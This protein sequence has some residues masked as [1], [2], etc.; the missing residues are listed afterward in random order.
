MLCKNI[1]SRK[2]SFVIENNYSKY[3][4]R[5]VYFLVPN[6]YIPGIDKRLTVI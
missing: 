3:M 6:G 4:L 1:L 5:K 2:S